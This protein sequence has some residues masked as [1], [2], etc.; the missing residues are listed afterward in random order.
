MGLAEPTPADLYLYEWLR[1]TSM[2]VLYVF[3]MLD[4]A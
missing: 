2:K 1:D 4:P 3:R